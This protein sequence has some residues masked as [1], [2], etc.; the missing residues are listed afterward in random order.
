[1]SLFSRRTT[2][3]TIEALK[4]EWGQCEA[5][6]FYIQRKNVVFGVGALGVTVFAVGQ[7]PADHE[8]ETGI[9]FSGKGGQVTVAEFNKIEIPEK[10]VW[11][12]NVLACRPFG[13]STGIQQAWADN[14]YDR[15]EGELLIVKP[16]MIVAM[17]APASKRFLPSGVKGELRGRR[18]EYRGIPGLTIMHPA[19][20]LRKK[21]F[22]RKGGV[23][24]AQ[25]DVAEDMA[26]V[27]KLYEEVTR[28]GLDR[29][30][31][32]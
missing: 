17:G 31:P 3:T 30:H 16:K 13:W 7:A 4:A 15:L 27:K 32:A 26:K 24:T 11:W 19:A 8:D 9:P 25:E 22:R 5:C 1:M 14:C 23:S 12:T 20:L 10:N 28:A 29:S 2:A 18:F 6:P 21:N